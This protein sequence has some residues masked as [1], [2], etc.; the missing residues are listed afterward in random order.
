MLYCHTQW[1]YQ[2]QW[3][4]RY[5]DLSTLFIITCVWPQIAALLIGEHLEDCS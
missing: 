4:H 1:F 2:Q 5:S 3:Y